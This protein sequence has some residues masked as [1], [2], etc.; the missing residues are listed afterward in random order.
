MHFPSRLRTALQV[1]ALLGFRLASRHAPA[2]T[3]AGWAAGLAVLARVVGGPVPPDRLLTA[4]VAFGGLLGATAGPRLLIRGGPLETLRWAF[5]PGVGVALARVLGAVAFAGGATAV[6]VVILGESTPAVGALGAGVVHAGLVAA[7]AAGLAPRVGCSA[8]TGLLTL[9][10][11]AGIA[12][13]SYPAVTGAP[14]W[15]GALTPPGVLLENAVAGVPG[16]ALRL[17]GWMVI[18]AAALA[19]TR[20]VPDMR[21]AR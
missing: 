10:V 1:E 5:L 4:A 9:F 18:A 3:A 20:R 21:G 11:A 7:L 6:V 16:T 12:R 2:R 14:A 8:T 17:C 15:V 19:N 13:E